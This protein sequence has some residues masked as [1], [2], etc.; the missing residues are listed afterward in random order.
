MPKS[1]KEGY[2][3]TKNDSKKRQK[4]ILQTHQTQGIP[5]SMQYREISFKIQHF[6][7]ETQHSS[8]IFDK[9]PHFS[10]SFDTK[11][12]MCS[13]KSKYF[14]EKTTFLPCGGRDRSAAKSII[15]NAKFLVFV[16]DFDTKFLVFV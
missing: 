4:T 11:P 5:F 14:N 10:N 3:T 7:Y 6:Q 15:L 12:N 1:D 2:K 9:N 16:C 13:N 8:N